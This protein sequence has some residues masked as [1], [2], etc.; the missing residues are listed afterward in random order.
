MTAVCAVCGACSRQACNHI[1]ARTQM[2]V[3]S[4]GL[5]QLLALSRLVELNAKVYCDDLHIPF[6]GYEPHSMQQRYDALLA[7]FVGLCSTFRLAG[8][9]LTTKLIRHARYD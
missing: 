8:R 9:N 1:L 6:C 4:R 5:Q 2:Q 7:A 3:S